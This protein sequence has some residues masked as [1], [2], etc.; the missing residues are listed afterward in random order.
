MPIKRNRVEKVK[1]TKEEKF[2]REAINEMFVFAGHDFDYDRIIEH[3]YRLEAG[4]LIGEWYEF[5]TWT[6]EQHSDYKHWFIE[7]YCKRFRKNKRKG[8]ESGVAAFESFDT[9]YGLRNKNIV[10]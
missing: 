10:E 2:L 7:E 8:P 1:L 3:E 4:I 5:F 9:I 6:T